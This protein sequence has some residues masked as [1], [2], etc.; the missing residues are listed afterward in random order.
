VLRGAAKVGQ[1]ALFV[2]QGPH[3]AYPHSYRCQVH[4]WLSPGTA[5]LFQLDFKLP[6]AFSILGA[7]CLLREFCQDTSCATIPLSVY[8]SGHAEGR[9]INSLL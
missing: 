2:T 9:Q 6:A 3:A 5:T 7:G 1:K 8:Y 4:N